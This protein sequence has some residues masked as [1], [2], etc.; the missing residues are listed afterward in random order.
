MDTVE[1][2]DSP[3]QAAG[4]ALSLSVPIRKYA[5]WGKIKEIKVLR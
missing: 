5:I 1:F 3:Q 2:D 4:N